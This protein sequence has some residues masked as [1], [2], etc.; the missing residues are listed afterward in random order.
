[1]IDSHWVIEGIKGES[2]LKGLLAQTLSQAKSSWWE[3][4]AMR[5][6]KICD[7]QRGGAS[8]HYISLS[9]LDVKTGTWVGGEGQEV[10]AIDPATSATSWKDA[11]SPG[12]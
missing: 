12:I 2:T 7:P 9:A 8:S 11:L 6:P 5:W 3:L 10:S 4:F 1:M